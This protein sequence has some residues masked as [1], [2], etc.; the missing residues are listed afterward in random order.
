MAT[1]SPAKTPSPQPAGVDETVPLTVSQ[2]NL[3]ELLYAL[4]LRFPKLDKADKATFAAK[5]AGAP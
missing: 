3:R 2:T 1:R 5:V 4:N